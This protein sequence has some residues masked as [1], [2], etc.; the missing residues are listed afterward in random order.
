MSDISIRITGATGRIT[1]QRPDALNALSYDM[2]L[3]I[4]A[5]LKAWE[6][7]D[8]VKMIVIDAEGTRAF[9]AGGDI[10]EMYDTGMAGDFAYGQRFW[11][12]EYRMNARLFEFP[13]PVA[14][15]LQG[16]TMG[17]GVGVGCHGSHRV[18]GDTSMIAMPECGIGLVPDVGGSLILARA[19]G[20]LGEYL[21]TTG[22]RMGPGDAILAGFADYY[23]PEDTWPELIETLERTGD[24]T[25]IDTAA[26]TP[27]IGPIQ[28]A[29]AEIN[30]LFTGERLGD[31]LKDLE[32]DG[33]EFAQATLA[34]M[35][36]NAPL[37]MA[38]AID[39]THRLRGDVATIRSALELEY[40]FTHRA[41][42][43]ADF[44]EGIRA[45]IIDKDRTPKWQHPLEAVPPLAV[46]QMLMPLGPD[47]LTFEEETP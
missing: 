36:R 40:R 39:M 43:N 24:W 16:F 10:Q 18:V 19:P 37:S 42:E 38:C 17:G 41:M 20:R 28:N 13:K 47:K 1:L 4:D 7:N 30:R 9:C 6:Y 15:F 35:A 5:A 31:I 2:C 32:T 3:Q 34:M 21:G 29:R 12:D 44:L 33:S 14:S 27:P 46:S 22:A 11:R 45:A 23:I 26:L 8:T 25:Q